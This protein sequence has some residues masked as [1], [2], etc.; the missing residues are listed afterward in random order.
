LDGS[1]L[2]NFSGELDGPAG[3][4]SLSSPVSGNLGE[5]H[6][7]SLRVVAGQGILEGRLSAGCAE[8]IRW[9][10]RLV[11]SALDPGY[12][13]AELPG[14]LDGTLVSQGQLEGEALN[15][16]VDLRLR[17]TLRNLPA[18]L[19]LDG[20]VEGE[21]WVVPALNVQLGDNRIRGRGLLSSELAAELELALPRL[22]QLWPELAGA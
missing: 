15:A 17:G 8:A 14:S 6:L 7:P 20:R 12:W 22:E 4:F 1:Y 9:N 5:V 13:L 21:R 10:T 11:L 2:G 18:Q 3:P 16:Q 19:A